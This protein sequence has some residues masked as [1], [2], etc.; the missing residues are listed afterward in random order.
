MGTLELVIV[1]GVVFLLLGA[2]LRKR[3]SL[4]F[5]SEVN[6]L[7]NKGINNIKVVKYKMEKASQAILDLAK[8]AAE[9]FA[10]EKVLEKKITRL[11][12][13]REDLTKDAVKYKKKNKEDK[14]K[15]TLQLRLTVDKSLELSKNQMISLVN[16][17]K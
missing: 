2:T 6:H 13:K 4:L 9:L 10:E 17:R 1:G 14:A 8:Q 7:T 16:S 11:E 12:E 3:I 5:K 15:K